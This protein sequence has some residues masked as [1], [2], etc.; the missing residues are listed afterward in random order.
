MLHFTGIHGMITKVFNDSDNYWFVYMKS[1]GDLARIEVNEYEI[2]G[3]AE[4]NKFG[5]QKK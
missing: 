4:Y 1:D 5:F 2:D 3:Y